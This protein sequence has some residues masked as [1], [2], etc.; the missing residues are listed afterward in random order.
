MKLRTVL[1]AAAA[2]TCCSIDLTNVSAQASGRT[3][4]VALIFDP[5][6]RYDHGKNQSAQDG[7][8]RAVR[9][10]GVNVDTYTPQDA[11]DNRAGTLKLA[12]EGS[13][14]VIGVG[15][16]HMTGLAAAAQQYPKTA[17]ALVDGLPSGGNTAGLRFRDNEGAY[18]AGYLAGTFSAT[19]VVGMVAEAPGSGTARFVAAFQSG[20]RL[21]CPD[22]RII[23]DHLDAGS[24]PEQDTV[25]AH[26]LAAAMM[27][28][29]ADI[30]FDA[31]LTGATGPVQAV[32]ARQCLKEGALPRGVKFR[33]DLF[34]AVPKAEAY[35][36]AC[37][38]EAR[39][40]FYIGW[41]DNSDVLGDTD[42]DASTLNHGLTSIVRRVDNAVY[43]VIRDM[44]RGQG[45]RPGERSFGLQNGGLEYAVDKY[46]A[47]IFSKGVVERLTKFI[48]LVVN[49]SI[50]IG[51]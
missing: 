33:S 38:G 35:R 16:F 10:F 32:R 22:C 43:S 39:P 42:A 9:D 4:N 7:A 19:A 15:S 2:V 27:N 44:V 13:D 5:A 25:R 48:G 30:I 49:G 20:V 8:D 24:R 11:Q 26:T 23:V 45:W 40:V 14:L 1:L 17:F 6:G 51:E 31:N 34:A 36:G 21:V 12:R 37:K 47:A 18:L 50:K 41:Q 3:L 46:N 29:G 28:E